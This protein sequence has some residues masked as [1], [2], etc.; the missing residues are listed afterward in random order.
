MKDAS[1]ALI[2]HIGRQMTTLTTCVKITRT[3]NVVLAFT[4]LDQPFTFE[5]VVHQP[6]YDPSA[7]ASSDAMNVDNMEWQGV[8]DHDDITSADIR[9]GKYDDA[10][11]QIYRVNWADLTQGKIVLK[12]GT[13][14]NVS[15]S[16]PN[17]FVAEGRSL[18]QAL[19]VKVGMHYTPHCKW[20][21]GDGRCKFQLV[22]DI[23]V[24]ALASTSIPVWQPNHAYALN[25]LVSPTVPNGFT[26]VCVD[27]GTSAATEPDW[28]ILNGGTQAGSRSYL[29][30]PGLTDNKSYVIRPVEAGPYILTGPVGELGQARWAWLT[31]GIDPAHQISPATNTLGVPNDGT[32]TT[33]NDIL[34][35]IVEASIV[36]GTMVYTLTINTFDDAVY[37]CGEVD[38]LL[39]AVGPLP[40]VIVNEPGLIGFDQQHFISDMDRLTLTWT[41]GVQRASHGNRCGGGAD[42][43]I[44][45]VSVYF[46]NVITDESLQYQI[47]TSDTR[48]FHPDGSWFNDD[49][50]FYGVADNITRYG[51][52]Y[53]TV[54]GA[55]QSFTADILDR[56]IELMA[57]CPNPAI[58]ENPAHWKVLMYSL[59][60]FVNGEA[61]IR[62][63]I[64]RI[65]MVVDAAAV[66]IDSLPDGGVVWRKSG[67]TA[68]G[69]VPN[70]PTNLTATAV[71][72]NRINLA[73]TDNATNE[74]GTDI[75]RSTTGAPGTFF[76]I[77]TV[78]TNVTTYSDLHLQAGRYYY[79]RVRAR[80]LQG[81]SAY[82]NVAFAQTPT[83]TGLP[84]PPSQLQILS[85]A[86]NVAVLTW[87]D[88]ATNETGFK[89]EQSLDGVSYTP[90]SP[91]PAN[92]TTTARYT[93][94]NLTADTDYWWRVKATNAAGDSIYSNVV[95]GHTAETPG[96]PGAPAAPSGLTITAVADT[97]IHFRWTDNASNETN[98]IVEKSLDGTIYATD[99]G[100]T[101]AA[102]VTTFTS[103][104]LTPSTPYWWRVKATNLTGDSAYSNVVT[105]T[106]DATTTAPAAPTQLVAVAPGG[107]RVVLTWEDNSTNETGFKIERGTNGSDFTQIYVTQP[108]EESYEDTIPVGSERVFYRTRATNS[109]GNSAYSNIASVVVH[110]EIVS[111]LTNPGLTDNKSYIIRPVEAGQPYVLEGPVGELGQARWAVLTDGV[112][113]T[114]QV[115]H[116]TDTGAFPTDGIWHVTNDIQSITVM[117]ARATG[118]SLEINTF[119][120]T[121]YGC[122]EVNALVTAVTD[123]PD[124]DVPQPG[125]LALEDQQTLGEVTS[126]TLTWTQGVQRASFGM[127]CGD[128]SAVTSMSVY[129]KNTVTDEALR[130]Q[131]YTYDSR[132]AHPDGLWHTASGPFYRVIDNITRYGG[133]Y[134]AVGTATVEFTAD[135]RA[136]VIALLA[137]CPN[138]AIDDDPDHW[139]IT[140]VSAGPLVKGAADILSSVYDVNLT[141]GTFVPVFAPTVTNVVPSA[142]VLAGGT[143]VT[144]TGT[145]F[146]TGATVTFGGTSATGVSVVN[147]TTITATTPAHAGGLVN[148]VVTNPNTQTGTLT[149]GYEYT[150]T[151]PPPPALTIASISPATGSTAGGTQVTIAGTHFLSGLTLTFGGTAAAGITVV[152]ST[153]LVATTPAHAAGAVNVV[154]TNPDTASATLT[155]G[156]TYS[157]TT[158]P[159]DT[160]TI[161]DVIPDSGSQDGGTEVAI[162]GAG[163]VS[164][165]TITFGGSAATNVTFVN[166]TLLHARTP[167][168]APGAVNVVVTN[169]DT[170]TATLVNGYTY[171]TETVPPPPDGDDDERS[172]VTPATVA[173]VIDEHWEF[174]A[175]TTGTRL[176][177]N[178]QVSVP[179]WQ[180]K[181]LYWPGDS[182]RPTTTANRLRAVA[183]GVV[184][185]EKK[186][187]GDVPSG[188]S[189]SS[190]PAWPTTVGERI[191]D[192][193]VVWMMVEDQWYKDGVLKFTSG[194]NVGLVKQFEVLLY[195]VTGSSARFRLV[196]P[197]PYAIQV[198]D[199]FIVEAGCDKTHPTCDYKFHNILNFGGE[200]YVAGFNRPHDTPTDEDLIS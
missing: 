159:P 93:V 111:Y 71:S 37:H 153:L 182:V 40:D 175:L 193:E 124:V 123:L 22:G 191:E 146:V 8:I 17:T 82:S 181:H 142:G 14:G 54:G 145:H 88:N 61:D 64:S 165:A 49:G 19:Q 186:K 98:F 3:D 167:A 154:V 155:N 79:Y 94:Q 33:Q 20:D 84:A 34:S 63:T 197:T 149:N 169:P 75:E 185:D 55:D 1:G 115:S 9:A 35:G 113:A 172:F 27:P 44:T 60:P 168:H 130:Y 51:K 47:Y 195:I 76:P 104:G 28:T 158:T 80:N 183:A 72:S 107:S 157:T 67:T 189:G 199:T 174:T 62:S 136:R 38:L 101:L 187:T 85:I 150:N 16:Y 126:L 2:A 12:T 139:K 69:P 121:A 21:L 190:E 24:V 36:G 31:D 120:N 87:T 42:V 77:D 108:N 41:Q 198:G 58:D 184:W 196:L 32:W 163:F 133:T 46:K 128:D 83:Q 151:P 74:T 66:P 131:I 65:N 56:V 156:F 89:V 143:A 26:Y 96:G 170:T 173:T 43:A 15:L 68:P 57:T 97:E 161:S 119:D 176:V 50:P 162:T 127:R 141:V 18:V 178:S 92:P 102:N 59:G 132:N 52:P 48:G 6:G 164:G 110:A 78:V 122:D 7:V 86:H 125:I 114:H 179:F 53:V 90:L 11:W 140:F 45:M 29:T 118:Y 30:D 112:G 148:V 109:A 134:L 171:T 39:C 10:Q 188:T 116:V 99:T 5:G 117:V 177:T 106:T 70:A 13:I 137:A 194:N 192:N 147:S 25:D 200:P 103:T 138:P 81:N 105:V 4:A 73:F 152:N 129:F 180:P 91:A 166:S 144:M 135:I 160:L 100:G 23:G 95:M